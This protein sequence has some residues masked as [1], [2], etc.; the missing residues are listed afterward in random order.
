M[1]GKQP[2]SRRDIVRLLGTGVAGAAL[3]E[4]TSGAESR[5]SV[6]STSAPFTDPTSK[7]PKPP[8]PGQ[9]QPWPG[10][11]SKMNPRPDHGETSYKGP[12]GLPGGRRSLQAPIRA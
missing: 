12:G 4:G 2:F 3:V 10:L 8:Y 9:S 5:P 6:N 7:Y 1:N 11:A